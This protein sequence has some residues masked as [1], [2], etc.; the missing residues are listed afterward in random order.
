MVRSFIRADTAEPD[1]RIRKVLP[2]WIVRGRSAICAQAAHTN[3]VN[4]ER[5]LTGY[6]GAIP[7]G[8]AASP[9][10]CWATGQ[11]C[12]IHVAM[13][14]RHSQRVQ[15]RE[16]LR[17]ERSANRRIA[18]KSRRIIFAVSTAEE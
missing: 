3:N 1:P 7:Y 13:G 8:D 14:G 17:P 9:A 6:P 16:L 11:R 15:D 10:A 12:L 18:L 4:N 5:T 2:C